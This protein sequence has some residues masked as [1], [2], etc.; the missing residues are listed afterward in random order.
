MNKLQKSRVFNTVSFLAVGIVLSASIFYGANFVFAVSAVDEIKN[1]IE[2]RAKEVKELEITIQRYRRELEANEKQEN[3]LQNQLN[4]MNKEISILNLNIKKAQTE[5][6]ETGLKIE[7][8]KNEI[9][10]KEYEIDDRKN[11]LANI[12]RLIYQAES[13]NFLALALSSKNL[14]DFFSQQEYL[15]SLQKEIKVN[16]D[17]LKAFKS[18]LENFKKNHEDQQLE[19]KVLNNELGSQW[20]ITN[21][22]KE[23]KDRLLRETK[24]KEKEYQRMIAELNRKRE[25]VESEINELEEK[26]RQAID[27]SKIII[28]KG[29]LRWPAEGRISQNYGKPNWNAAYT[30]HNGI[31]IAAP[32][33]TP[34]RAALGGK[35]IGVGDNGRYSYGKW[36][37]ID[38]GNFN[39]TTLYGHLS[40][41]KVSIGQEVKTG[42]IVGYVGST[43]YSTGSHLHFTVFTSDSYTLMKSTKVQNLFIPIGGT[44]N[45]M[46][47]L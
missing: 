7:E 3:T 46:E 40:L 36:I 28:G 24:N 22:K 18:K 4:K 21:E 5:I 23:E 25:E 11:K 31:D 37:A 39:I 30:F 27:R 17:D 33:G 42:D 6:I 2:L 15:A 9:Y 20:Q 19:L 14:S 1:Q 47:Y 34:V 29:I 12:M 16:L 44:I 45:P 26:L 43:G 32:T 13:S 35:I 38:H 41:Q 8:T 10:A